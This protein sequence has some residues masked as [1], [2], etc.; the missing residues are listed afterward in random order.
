[1]LFTLALAEGLKAAFPGVRV[2]LLTSR[3]AAEL[4]ALSP[5]LDDVVSVET[6]HLRSVRGLSDPRT[7]AGYWRLFWRLRAR[8]FDLAIAVYGQMGSLGAGLSGA[9]RTVGYAHEAYP[10]LLTDAVPGGRHLDR[11]H[12]AEYVRV[13]ARHVGVSSLPDH[14][15]IRVP[16]EASR[17]IEE[18]LRCAGIAAADEVVV[19][20]AGSINGSA[21]R[22]PANNWSRFATQVAQATGARIV[23]VGA[24]GDRKIADEVITGSATPIRSLVGETS[25]AELAAVLQRADLVASGDSG[26]LHL[27]VALGRPVLA[28]Y[29]PTDPEVY[30]PYR[31]T[32]PV[33]L[34]RRDLP[35][36]PCYSLKTIAECPLGDP[37][38]MRLV[39]VEAMV[40]SA[41]EMLRRS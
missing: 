8:Q 31:P 19:I 18:K 6:H 35:C 28:V 27:A 29:G 10:N 1:M 22:W 3:Y 20:H 33:Q 26:P 34:H 24:A 7:W 23:L 37:I 40:A 4:A 17:S 30:G 9:R 38:C 11:K 12:E 16:V 41:A 2:T 32:A 13:L 36:S 21:K 5:A 15:I 14:P 25:L 39:S